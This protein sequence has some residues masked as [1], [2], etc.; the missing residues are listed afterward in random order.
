MLDSVG[1]ANSQQVSV[2]SVTHETAEPGAVTYLSHTNCDH[3][4]QV[5]HSDSESLHSAR[6]AIMI[7]YQVSV[8][9]VTHCTLP[10]KCSR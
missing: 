5:E 2:L 1:D 3:E 7:S 4:L 6:A 8:L 10:E 9:T